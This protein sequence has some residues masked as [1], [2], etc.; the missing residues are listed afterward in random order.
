MYTEIR[1]IFETLSEQ[2][3]NLS[4][5]LSLRFLQSKIFIIAFSTF[6]ARNT[7]PMHGNERTPD[8]R[9]NSKLI[10]M[11]CGLL[12]HAPCHHHIA[13]QHVGG[14]MWDNPEINFK[15]HPAATLYV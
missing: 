6:K 1:L 14:K 15:R 10:V 9:S 2:S 11:F 4:C 13:R 3:L 5:G 7:I 8:T 12:P